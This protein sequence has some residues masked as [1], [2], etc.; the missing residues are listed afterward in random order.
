MKGLNK[1]MKKGK[2]V[3]L[4]Y[5]QGLEHGPVDFNDKNVDPNYII[6]IARKGGYSGVVF[7]KGIAEKYNKEIKKSKV[8]LIL[9][10]NGKSSLVKGDPVSC[11]ICS[12]DEAIKLGAVGVGYTIYLG[13]K[14]EAK[15]FSEFS[16]IQNE[17]HKK[18]LFVIVW[19]YPR[20]EGIKGKSEGE[21]MAYAARV[22]LELGAD[23]VKIH[24][25]GKLKDFKWAKESA[26]RVKVLAAGGS[27]RNEK[28]L[29]KQIKDYM[30]AGFCGLA[31]GRNVWQSDDPMGL[32]KKIREVVFKK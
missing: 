14:H 4:A 16:N 15:M 31:I 8:P 17:A 13:S 6:D 23:I 10:L 3:F 25:V 21:L 24:P 29:L 28:E 5:D 1:V 18:G 20:G 12:V 19:M 27:K 30:D 2:A 11:Q 26:G 7:Q 32:T 22:A 9:K